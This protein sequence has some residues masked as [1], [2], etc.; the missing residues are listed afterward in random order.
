MKRKLV[1]VIV[2]GVVLVLGIVI[3][4]SLPK[5]YQ[6]HEGLTQATL[7][8][9]DKEAFVILDII[10]VGRAQNVVQK[11]IASTRYGS[12]LGFSG[13]RLSRELTAYHLLPSGTLERPEI[14][15]EA[16]RLGRWELVEGKLQF[17][18]DAN[19]YKDLPGFRW[20]GDR[21]VTVPKSR[22]SETRTTLKAD[23]DEDDEPTSVLFGKSQQAAF[24]AAGW[25]WKVLTG[26]EGARGEATLDLELHDSK[27]RVMLESTPLKK[28]FDA[29]TDFLA[30]GA[31]RL[32]LSGDRM[33]GPTTLW[34]QSG[35]QKIAKAEYERRMQLSGPQMAFPT[36][37]W[38]WLAIL[39]GLMGW[40]VWA[41]IRV[42]FS[43]ATVKRRV[44][45]NMATVL[46]FPPA[47][48]AQFPR[49]DTAALERYTR[50]FDSMGFARLIDTSP[51][52]DSPTHPSMFCRLMVHPDHHCYGEISQIFPRGK[53]PMEMRCAISS[54]L[55]NGWSVA[56]SNRKPLAASSL[57][58]RPKALGVSMPDGSPAELLQSLLTLRQQVCL[59]L[60][61]TPLTEDS[62]ESYIAKAQQSIV[63]M[64]AAVKQKNFV[65]G[66]PQFYYRK[67]ALARTKPE[68]VWLG[69]Y[70]KEAEQR[71]QGYSMAPV[72]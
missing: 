62:L 13:T 31:S 24:K 68:Y 6:V 64:R 11:E 32:R 12:I 57:I 66:L 53:A 47:S 4:N 63:D 21:F 14:P 71:K 46:S 52:S 70:P 49:L 5:H 9:N 16:S 25:H 3:V 30:A 17:T 67:L 35:W 22:T 51:T 8:W 42:I 37:I 2:M 58:R 29:Q 59:D 56:F 65:T 38:I 15:K 45:N 43:F 40:K 34:E 36:T 54:H 41:W 60:G 7:F 44:I 33:P 26:Y 10:V 55:Q 23:N 69:A 50:E 18:T 72:G 48:A 1:F 20:D 27:F 61:I 28:D 19:G 39:L